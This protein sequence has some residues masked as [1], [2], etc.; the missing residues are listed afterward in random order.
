[1]ATIQSPHQPR[2]ILHDISWETYERLLADH[3]DRR[4][5]RFTYDRGTLEIMS[6]IP[7][8]ERYTWAIDR[9][10]EAVAERVGVDFVNLGST[11]FKREDMQR[12]FEP[13]GC[14]YMR[15][16]AEMRTKDRIDLRVD[17]PPELVIEVDITHTSPSKLPIFA[18]VGVTEVWRY[19]GERLDIWVLEGG[20]H[21]PGA[22]SRV[23]PTIT[24]EAISRLLEESK[25][26]GVSGIHWVRRVRAWTRTLVEGTEK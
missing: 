18:Q 22:R 25:V 16:A 24:A 14:F 21:V 6:P 1:M 7:E 2:V 5:P 10:V 3:A 26:Q 15:H 17:P 8:H 4:A 9:L 13:D 12:G 11:T 19:D 23:L 20:R